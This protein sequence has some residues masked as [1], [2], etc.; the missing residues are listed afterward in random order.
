MNT[1]YFVIS[2]IIVLSGYFWGKIFSRFFPALRHVNT[3]ALGIAAIYGAFEL[4]TLIGISR[5]FE[6]DIYRY[7]VIAILAASPLLCLI[8]RANVLPNLNDLFALLFSVAFTALICYQSTTMNTNNLY[9]DSVFYLS[10]VIDSSASNH[11]GYLLSFNG[12][13]SS[14]IIPVYDYNGFYY[15]WG[16]ILR[17]YDL[18]Y[19]TAESLAPMYIWSSTMVYG[20][21]LG[22]TVAMSIQLV[23]P[24]L[25][26]KNVLLA[27]LIVAFLS[28]YYVNY[29]N[30]DL[31][32]FGNTSRAVAVGLAMMMCYLYFRES[33]SRY[34]IL[35]AI[36]SLAGLS[37]SSSC[38]FQLSFLSVA[39]FLAAAIQKKNSRRFF[40]WFF[41]G[42]SPLILFFFLYEESA[43]QGFGMSN[44]KMA[45]IILAALLVLFLLS[46]LVR[47][48]SRKQMNIFRVLILA[49]Y[50]I[51]F[52]FLVYK[53]RPF[54]DTELGYSYFFAKRSADD[55]V[56]DYVNYSSTNELIRN[57]ML[58]A[59]LAGSLLRFRHQSGMKVM[60]VAIIILFLNPLVC[61]VL[62]KYATD[63]AYCRCFELIVNP[64]MLVFLSAELLTIEKLSW[65]IAVLFAALSGISAYLAY[66][67]ITIPV[68]AM[69]VKNPEGYDWKTKVSADSWDMYTYVNEH[70]AGTPENR[71]K[72]LTTD[73]AIKGYVPNIT[74]Y[75]SAMDVRTTTQKGYAFDPSDPKNRALIYFNPLGVMAEDAYN[76]Y[77]ADYTKLPEV[78]SSTGAQYV[79]MRVPLA[80]L[81]PKGWYVEAYKYA[82][83]ELCDVVYMNSSYVLLK[84]K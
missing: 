67:T 68:N 34:M 23:L 44:Q 35:F 84:V 25:R 78:I 12:E 57:L 59:V 73:V 15:F 29:F 65:L 22:S 64:F 77:T 33:S 26:W 56:L 20:M 58:Y 51:L 39:F 6:T 43:W 55:M 18:L 72:I 47:K 32:F 14:Q 71:T 54:A 1:E 49:A 9:F 42:I 38:F 79:I 5:Y 28:P 63:V 19:P 52:G 40:P 82:T 61:P 45:T 3:A 81:D 8:F 83:A 7:A 4:L 46:F 48:L 74:L 11:L 24:E 27:V 75:F 21:F 53:S 30:T 37:F 66:Q 2:A 80:V 60:M 17:Q 50:L 62:V 13:V 31:A 41:V 36:V 16:M 10:R 70:V 76:G 69:V